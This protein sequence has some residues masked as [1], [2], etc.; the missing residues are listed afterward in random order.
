[1]PAAC[2]CGAGC[3][4]GA[5]AAAASCSCGVG[6]IGFV[7]VIGYGR[8]SYYGAQTPRELTPEEKAEEAFWLKKHNE[9]VQEHVRKLAARHFSYKGWAITPYVADPNGYAEMKWKA[10]KTNDRTFDAATYAQVKLSI[11]RYTDFDKWLLFLKEH[12]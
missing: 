1:M 5:C 3:A 8:S 10:T 2:T 4:A 9:H 6:G 11:L 7:P 12:I